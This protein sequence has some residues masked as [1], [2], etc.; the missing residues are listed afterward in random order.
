MV[1]GK[2]IVFSTITDLYLELSRS[3]SL[4]GLLL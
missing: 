1:S 3:T 4:F 2:F